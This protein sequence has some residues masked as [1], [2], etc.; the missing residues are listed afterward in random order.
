[1]TDSTHNATRRV[2]SGILDSSGPVTRR[3]RSMISGRPSVLPLV[4]L[5]LLAA[6]CPNR[7][8]ITCPNGQM[9]CGNRCIYVMNDPAN[10]G[11]CGLACPGSLACINGTCG[12]P[13]PLSNCGNVCVDENVDGNNCG[14]CGSSC[15]PGTVCSMA[16][17]AV[18]CGKNLKQ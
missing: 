13:M 2:A 18:T 15:Q 17:C 4:T 10:C 9:F 6:D 3:S 8:G 1:M 7:A 14:A 16:A 5:V 12:C 11:G